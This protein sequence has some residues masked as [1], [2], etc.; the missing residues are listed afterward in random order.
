ML[1]EQKLDL[2]VSFYICCIAL[3]ELMGAKTFP[4][5]NIFGYQLNASVAIFILPLIYSINDVITEV[6]GKERAKSVVR[7][8]ITIVGFIFMF[9]LLATYLPPSLRFMNTEDAY[10]TIFKLSIRISG[11][12]LIAFALADF[13]DV[14]VYATLREKFGKKKLWFR[15]NIS[16]FVSQFIDTVLFMTLA[17]WAFDKPFDTNVIFLWSL[18]LPYWLVKCFMSIIETPFVYL[19]VSWLQSDTKK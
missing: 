19:G 7:S 8:G 16:N 6:M 5:A 14:Y 2:I 13:L 10:D 18:I 11:A 9:S 1:R 3:S 15:N 17:F 12:S 4:L